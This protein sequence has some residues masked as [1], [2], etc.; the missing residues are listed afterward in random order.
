M[1]THTLG[2]CSPTKQKIPADQRVT[3]Q[4]CPFCLVELP[5]KSKETPI[6]AAIVLA[7]ARPPRV[8]TTDN[9]P[10]MVATD[11][12]GLI[13]E[14][15]GH[16]IRSEKD[17]TSQVVAAVSRAAEAMGADAVVGFRLELSGQVV[18]GYGTAVTTKPDRSLWNP[19]GPMNPDGTLVP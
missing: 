15:V 19:G 4:P 2:Y 8:V 18:Y 14:K 9:V 17:A 10:G 13:V 5:A 3:G 1:A 6:D 7:L 12:L 16:K 11:C